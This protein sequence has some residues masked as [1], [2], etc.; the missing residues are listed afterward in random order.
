MILHSDCRFKTSSPSGLEDGW[1]IAPS[2]A[3]ARCLGGRSSAG[4]AVPPHAAIGRGHPGRVGD[5]YRWHKL[6]LG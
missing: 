4:A 1:A 3:T 2:P 5:R 6:P